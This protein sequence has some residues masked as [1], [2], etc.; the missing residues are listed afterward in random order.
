MTKR[1]FAIVSQ[2][3]SLLIERLS[4]DKSEVLITYKELGLALN[5]NYRKLGQPL[6]K[7]AEI[8]KQCPVH[9]PIPTLNALIVYSS[10]K[11]PSTNGLRNA[12]GRNDI[13]EQNIHDIM[14]ELNNSAKQFDNW[15]SVLKSIH[16]N[17]FK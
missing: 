2:M 4:L 11:L 10:T 13:T 17:S 14:L 8:I 5:T 9:Q 16:D 7:M 6:L 12:T 15:K 3:I 1:Q